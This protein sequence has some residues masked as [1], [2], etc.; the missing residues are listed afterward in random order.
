MCALIKMHAE[1]RTYRFA[2]KKTELPL[3]MQ[4]WMGRENFSL[5]QEDKQIRYTAL[6]LL[7]CPAL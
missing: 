6:Q 7:L 1:V 2:R 5:E 4:L 3:Q